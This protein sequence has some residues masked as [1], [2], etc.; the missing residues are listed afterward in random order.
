MLL[1]DCYDYFTTNTIL[2]M[3]VARNHLGRYKLFQ[4]T[5]EVSHNAHITTAY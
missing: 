1:S 4:I 3:L 5:F 2:R